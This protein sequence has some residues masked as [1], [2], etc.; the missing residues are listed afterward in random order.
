MAAEDN[1][2]CFHASGMYFILPVYQVIRILSEK[3]R[4]E[5][6]H[7]LFRAD[8]FGEIP[9]LDFRKGRRIETESASDNEKSG[10]IIVLL[11]QE[12]F[13]ITVERIEGLIEIKPEDQY[14]FPERIRDER[15]DF[16]SG[17]SYWPEKKKILYL[18]DGEHLRKYILA[19]NDP[20]G[21]NAEAFCDD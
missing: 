3:L 15:N 19:G 5:E 13:G 1:F 9:I 18:L 8:A 20:N 12:Y 17:L 7:S 16:I 2:L 14:E 10:S 11:D 21:K 6:D 4:H